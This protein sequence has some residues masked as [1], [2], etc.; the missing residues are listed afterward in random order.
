[1]VETL[2]KVWAFVR[3]DFLQMAS[4]RTNFVFSMIGILFSSLTF[5]FFSLLFGGKPIAALAPYGGQ[6]FPF[7]LVGIAFYQFLGTGIGALSE[8][9]GRA[10]TT[11]TLEA[12]LVTPTSLTTVIFSSTI[13]A[14]LFSAA[15]VVVFLVVGVVVF[16][17][18]L[19]RANVPAALFVLGLSTVNFIAIGMLSASWIMV[20]KGG[21]PTGFV[22]GGVSGLLGGVLFPQSVMYPWMRPLAFALPIT[23]ALEAMRRSVLLGEGLA[24]LWQPIAALVVFTVILLPAGVVA[25][26]LAVKRAKRTGSLVQY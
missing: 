4:Y 3:R 16:G 22:F 7:A 10:Q 15:R 8:S 20:F 12:L 19:S 1:V 6:Y 17:V 21:S 18:D 25:F 14:F 9:I 24:D 11:G 2:R 13:F 26:S 23:H 5:Y